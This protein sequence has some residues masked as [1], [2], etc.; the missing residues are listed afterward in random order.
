MASSLG[1]SR[2]SLVALISLAFVLCGRPDLA[3]GQQGVVTNKT[4][5]PPTSNYVPMTAEDRWNDY[6][7]QNF[8]QPG[9]F[10]QTFFTAVG[11]QTANVPSEWG[12]SADSFPQRLGSEFARFTI[13]GTIKST[14]A[15]GLR[16]DTRFHPCHFHGAW[17]RTIHAVSRT[18]LT[19]NQDGK[20]TLDIAGLAGLY[21][22]PMVMTRWYPSRYNGRWGM[23]S[24][25]E[26]SPQG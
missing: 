26:I 13:G 7:R 14:I 22:G 4:L 10:F 2:A 9:V 23:E 21:S 17:H 20:R 24:G 8:A 18:L 25:K 3:R 12:K 6:V 16:E 5:L 1:R 19:Y 15:A 11:D